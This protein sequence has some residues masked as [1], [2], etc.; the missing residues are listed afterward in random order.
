MLENI[1][2][3]DRQTNGQTDT[4]MLFPARG[5]ETITNIVAATVLSES[6][7]TKVINKFNSE[8]SIQ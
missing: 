4:I 6:D 8:H 7:F 1:L 3:M 5:N 2:L